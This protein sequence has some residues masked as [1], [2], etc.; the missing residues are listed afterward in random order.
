MGKRIIMFDFPTINDLYNSYMPFVIHGG[1]FIP[2]K[3]VFEI[4]EAVGL[5][6]RIMEEPDRQTLAGQ[7]IWLTPLGAQGGKPAGIGIQFE[8]ALGPELRN[9]IET[10]LAGKLKSA[11]STHTM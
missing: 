9:R 10:H 11:N 2:T 1:I 3:E 6:L 7:V 8:E 5:D 4:G